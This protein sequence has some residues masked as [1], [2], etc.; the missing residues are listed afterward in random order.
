MKPFPTSGVE[1]PIP[2]KLDRTEW[3]RMLGVSVD[4]VALTLEAECID[5]HLDSFIWTRLCGYDLGR[6][7]ER[8]PLGRYMLGHADFPRAIAGGL[9]GAVWIVTTNP[10]R[11]ERSRLRTL[12]RNIQEL[13]DLIARSPLPISLVTTLAQYREAR[14][15]KR[16][17]AFLGIQGANALAADPEIL[18]KEL[19]QRLV[20]VTLVHLTSSTIGATSSP[21]GSCRDHGLGRDGP[22]L[23][24]AL[25]DSHVLVDLAHI[26]KQ[27]FWQA[28]ALQRSDTP[29]VVSHT[30][31]SGVHSHWR[32]LDDDQIRAVAN[33]GGVVGIL[34][35]TPFLARPTSPVTSATV[36][37][38]MAH[39]VDLV[40][41][42]HVSLGSDWDGAILPPRDL[43]NCLTLP[44]LVQRML[45]RR[46]S[47]SRVKKV[48]G[49]NFLR[50]LGEIRP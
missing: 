40:G 29:V 31:V 35:H 6:W 13:S 15:A 14:G 18:C 7:H 32:N 11:A 1:A 26:H 36:V 5:L 37:E 43:S 2:L 44:R 49:G 42:D 47:D 38:H 20:L 22:P 27:G 19:G 48:L 12:K 16:H 9:S 46:W 4:A 8:G 17:A 30:G 25:A 28:L 10:C 23:L 33:R 3:A 34:L 41:E 21:L 45:D 50:V 24:G 39:V